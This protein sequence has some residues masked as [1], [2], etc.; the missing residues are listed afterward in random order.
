MTWRLATVSQN[1]QPETGYFF[2]TDQPV[3]LTLPT[4]PSIGTTVY[5]GLLQATTLTVTGGV[6][7][8][9]GNATITTVGQLHRFIYTNPTYGWF[10]EQVSAGAGGGGTGDMLKSLYD[11][12]N[13]GI[14]DEADVAGL[15]DLATAIAGNPDP[16]NYYGTNDVGTKGFFTLPTGTGGSGGG[17]VT[18]YNDLTDKPTLGTASSKDSGTGAGEVLLLNET[19]KLPALDGSLLTNISGSNEFDRAL[20]QAMITAG[21]TI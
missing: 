11:T 20:V 5:A 19:N 9:G 4:S 15:A 6:I 13:D 16:L 21:V 17:G 18:S 10:Y 8:G 12:D 1:A 2:D 3:T 7:N 14:V